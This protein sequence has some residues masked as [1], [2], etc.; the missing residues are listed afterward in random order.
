MGPRLVERGKLLHSGAQQ[1]WRDT[2]SMGPRLVERGKMLI[3]RYKRLSAARLQWG[4][5]GR[6][7]KGDWFVTCMP[8]W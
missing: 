5:V 3:G 7:R 8:F 6:A 4:R 2:A 1:S